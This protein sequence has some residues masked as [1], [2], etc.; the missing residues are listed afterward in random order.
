MPDPA[1][2][3]VAMVTGRGCH[4]HSIIAENPFGILVHQVEKSDLPESIKKGKI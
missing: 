3:V 1:K 4:H 2:V